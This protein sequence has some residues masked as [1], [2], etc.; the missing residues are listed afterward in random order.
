MG[1]S[2]GP[3]VLQRPDGDV[4]VGITS[5]RPLDEP[6]CGQSRTRAQVET[7]YS[8]VDGD[9]AAWIASEMRRRP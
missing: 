9:H 6:L 7:R 1:D 2:G 4:L 3:L 5:R 8:R